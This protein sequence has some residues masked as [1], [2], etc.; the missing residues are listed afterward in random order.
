MGA[1]FSVLS[2]QLTTHLSLVTKVTTLSHA[3]VQQLYGLWL[4]LS[5]NSQNVRTDRERNYIFK[6]FSYSM[7]HGCK[8]L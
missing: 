2:T 7:P 1:A 3:A 4:Q 8:T 6:D 5:R